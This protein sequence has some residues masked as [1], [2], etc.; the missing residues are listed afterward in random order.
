MNIEIFNISYNDKI[1]DIN[2]MKKL[3]YIG[4]CCSV[5]QELLKECINLQELKWRLY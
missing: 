4:G 1:T 5:K 3:K 2:H